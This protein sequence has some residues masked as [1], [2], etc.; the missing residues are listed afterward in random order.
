[1]N[2]K[3]YR[4]VHLSINGQKIAASIIRKHRLW[5]C[6]LVEKLK[7]S[8]DEVHEIAEQLE[9]IKSEKLIDKL[10]QFLK[11]PSID[12]H[13]DPIPD[14]EGNIFKRKKVLLA[15]LKPMDETVLLAVK[16]SSDEFLKYL[17]KK[18]VAIGSV[19][20]VL[21]F[22]PFDGSMQIEIDSKKILITEEVSKNLLVTDIK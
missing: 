10:D 14:K 5:E 3:K 19:I 22:E 16:D 20:K 13:G 8:W 21:N 9:H 11:Y 7:F 6:F 15:S 1:M 2:Y 18:K 12:P 4:G 17:N